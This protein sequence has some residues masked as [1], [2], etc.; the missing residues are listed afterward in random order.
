MISPCLA[1]AYLHYVLDLWF[2]KRAKK[3][4]QGEAYLTRFVDDFVVAFQYK[5][6]AERFDRSLTER[7]LIPVLAGSPASIGGSHAR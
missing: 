5:R 6:D 7:L 3:D 1:N 4:M 2:E